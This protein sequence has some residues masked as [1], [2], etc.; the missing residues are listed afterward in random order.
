MTK[1][2]I[3]DRAGLDRTV[4][5]LRAGAER[6]PQLP[7]VA[8]RDFLLELHQAVAEVAGEWVEVSCRLKGIALDS[9]LAGEEWMTGPYVMLAYVRALAQTP[10]AG[11]DPLAG[12]HMRIRPN[13]QVVVDVLPW[14][15][16]LDLA[17]AA[18]SLG[19]Q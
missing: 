9:Q 17:V 15:L 5:E 2:S 11:R 13:G 3:L 4:G 1:T 16:Y 19:L 10:E 8:K 14:D 12:A 6:W 7:M 18:E